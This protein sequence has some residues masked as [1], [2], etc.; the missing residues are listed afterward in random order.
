[1]RIATAKRIVAVTTPG[2]ET[3]ATATEETTMATEET[4]TNENEI[5]IAIRSDGAGRETRAGDEENEE[6]EEDAIR[7]TR[8]IGIA[9][10]TGGDRTATI[11]PTTIAAILVVP[12]G[13][14]G[15]TEE[16]RPIGSAIAIAIAA[17]VVLVPETIDPTMAMAT[18]TRT[19]TIAIA[20]A[21]AIA[22]A[23][24]TPRG[25]PRG[26]S[27][28]YLPCPVWTISWRPYAWKKRILPTIIR[29]QTDPPLMTW[30]AERK[31]FFDHRQS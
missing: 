20:T 10:V 27:A 3:I 21:I 26:R 17:A 31:N 16:G 29:R 30:P 18:A 28:R 22:I 14:A 5:A 23:R 9:V 24:G 12:N 11:P 8:T 2:D 15:T 25:T 13:L 19:K 7:T 1:M 6:E 4:A